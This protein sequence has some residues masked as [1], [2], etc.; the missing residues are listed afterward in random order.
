MCINLLSDKATDPETGCRIAGW[1]W[2]TRKLNVLADAGDFQEIT[3][4][5]NGGFNGQAQREQ[6]Y[7][8]AKEV[9]GVK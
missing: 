8:K 6:Y 7:Q 3:K 1:F 5:I 9:L 4:K 2:N